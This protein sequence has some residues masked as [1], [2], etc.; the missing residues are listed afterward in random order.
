MRLVAT[1]SSIVLFAGVSASAQ[2]LENLIEEASQPVSVDLAIGV[3]VSGQATQTLAGAGLLRTVP[4]RTA[5]IAIDTPSALN[6][7]QA[8]ER[9]LAAEGPSIAADL[10]AAEVDHPLGLFLPVGT[11]VDSSRLQAQIQ[12]LNIE[13]ILVQMGPGALDELED[14]SARGGAVG[15][16]AG[17]LLSGMGEIEIVILPSGGLR[18]DGDSVTVQQLQRA[19]ANQGL[20]R[21]AR[22]VAPGD[23]PLNQIVPVLNTLRDAGLEVDV[24]ASQSAV[25][26][27]SEAD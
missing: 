26:T 17:E 23:L 13:R 25:V 16:R 4:G 1:V 2:N 15:A 22:V 6:A 19:V 10:V 18:V 5:V 3:S 24:D 12:G 11:S 9:S 8:A 7:R 20:A 14:L 27:I 21:T